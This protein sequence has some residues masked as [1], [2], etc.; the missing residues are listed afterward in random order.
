MLGLRSLTTK[1]LLVAI[2]F[3]LIILLFVVN[4]FR[5]TS[6]IRYSS[7]IMRLVSAEQERL[8]RIGGLFYLLTDRSSLESSAVSATIATEVTLLQQ[9][10]AHIKNDYILNDSPFRFDSHLLSAEQT[11]LLAP[12]VSAWEEELLAEITDRLTPTST[13]LLD[14]E[15]ARRINEKIAVHNQKAAEVLE[16]LDDDYQEF[17]SQF[18]LMRVAVLLFSALVV[19]VLAFFVQKHL[20]L[21]LRRLQGVTKDIAGGNFSARIDAQSRDE[22]GELAAHVNTMAARLEEVFAD[23]SFMLQKFEGLCRSSRTIM[24]ELSLEKLLQTIVDEARIFLDSQFAGIGIV[25]EKGELKTFIPSGLL[26]GQ[27]EAMKRGF[28]LPKGEGIIRYLMQEGK[29]LRIKNI[30]DHP[31]AVGF[32]QGH[33]PMS[34]FLGVPIIMDEQVIG[35]L[36]FTN[37]Q[38]SKEFTDLD[39]GWA[40]TFAETAAMAIDNANLLQ[41]LQ[42]QNAELDTL[43]KVSAA[44]SQ[45]SEMKEIASAALQAVLR[46]ENLNVLSTAGIFLCNEEQQTLELLASENFPPVQLETCGKVAYGNCLCGEAVLGGTPVISLSSGSDP[47]HTIKYT[48]IHDHGHIVLPLAVQQK[49]IGVLCLYLPANHS[50]SEHE[51]ALFESIASLIAVALQNALSRQKEA[52]LASFPEK[53]PYPIV[54]CDERGKISYFNKKMTQL[55]EED[56]FSF[57]DFLRSDFPVFVEMLQNASEK[58]VYVEKQVKDK[59]YGQHLH[60]QPETHTVRIYAFDISEQKKAEFEI[61]NYTKNLEEV[62]EQR[63]REFRQAKDAAEAASR[64]KSSFLANM[65]HELRTPLNSIIGFSD[66]LLGGLAGELSE[67]QKEYLGDIRSSGGHLLELIN[68]ILDLSKIEAEKMELEFSEVMVQ[69]LLEGCSMFIREKAMKHGIRLSI[70]AQEGVGAIYADERRLKQVVVNLL[71]NA[72]K[73]TPDHGS[74]TLSAA[75][76]SAADLFADIG[77]PPESGGGEEE[78]LLVSVEDSGCGIRDE[79]IGKLFQPFQQVGASVYRDK[80]EGTG[81]GLALSRKI[82]EY[83]GGRI[84]VESE[85]EK[86]STFSFVVPSAPKIVPASGKAWQNFMTHLQRFQSLHERGGTGFAVLRLKLTGSSDAAEQLRFPDFLNRVIRRHELNVCL[87][88]ENLAYVVL[89]GVDRAALD[90]ALARIEQKAKDEGLAIK[91]QATLFPDDGVTVEALMHTF[92]NGCGRPA[93][94]DKGKIHGH[95]RTS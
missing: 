89:M 45:H 22:I 29:P 82:V 54:E 10:V 12:L 52:W 41:N 37:K 94:Q 49:N 34:S 56:G 20:V 93:N 13:R 7:H 63:T 39:Q 83:H 65:S 25:D 87:A 74:I 17:L 15:E 71:S 33:S 43:H 70:V 81:L 4:S 24:R 3:L 51:R 86:G 62:V 30:A 48:H 68:E 76:V 53:S 8:A 21:P 42:V 40:T 59:V 35:R 67:D 95:T 78:Y 36:Y 88:Q 64:A 75:T 77:W 57:A 9:T 44:V 84:W 90:L 1:Y 18:R 50:V 26:P 2:S 46:L 85:Y 73:F 14:F 11:R 38:N 55:A 28:G 79:D 80:P 27:Y 60:L 31:A 6:G 16:D 58:S 32:P 5:L 72:A 19:L 69:E 47:R 61:A 23:R 91:T 66:L 92:Q